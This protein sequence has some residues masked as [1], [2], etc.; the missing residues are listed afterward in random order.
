M[1]KTL[2][3]CETKVEADKIGLELA[4]NSISSTTMHGDRSQEQREQAL[5]D[6]KA[7]KKAILV[8]TNVAARGRYSV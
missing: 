6:F 3:F 8:A 4:M 1:E 7:G 5:A 2:V